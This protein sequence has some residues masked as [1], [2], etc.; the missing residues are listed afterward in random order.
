MQLED[1]RYILI[2]GGTFDP[3]HRAHVELPEIVRGR[4][5]AD[6]IAYVPAARSPHKLD[7]QPTDAAHRLAMLRLALEDQPRAVIVTDE[8]D[9]AAQGD[10]PSYT[11]E[12]LQQLR[13][14]LGPEVRLRLLIGA[15]QVPA[16]EKWK[17]PKRI[18]ELAEPV[19]MLRPPDTAESLLAALPDDAARRFW[20]RRLMP[21]PA[22]DVSA[23]MVRQRVR[24]GEPIDDLVPEA[25][26]RYIAEQGLYTT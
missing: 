13:E 23:T 1:A 16:F 22:L 26:A 4:L 14:R 3:P 2:F 12:T 25:V 19:V 9:R 17:D 5:G 11:V 24:A 7:Q 15:D 10:D 8:L 20:A 21:V 6:C 18:I